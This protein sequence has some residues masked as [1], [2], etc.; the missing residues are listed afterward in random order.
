[1]ATQLPIGMKLEG[2]TPEDAAKRQKQINFLIKLIPYHAAWILI[3]KILNE[4]RGAVGLP[5][6][7]EDLEILSDFTDGFAGTIVRNWA[8]SILCDENLAKTPQSC[9]LNAKLT[10]TRSDYLHLIGLNNYSI[11]TFVT[12]EQKKEVT[13]IYGEFISNLKKIIRK[14][15]ELIIFSDHASIITIGYKSRYI[16]SVYQKTKEA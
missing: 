16:L 10:R 15:G 3:E 8:N 6:K 14:N 7:E 9:P 12:E 5:P 11:L 2:T 13:K 1:M 4:T